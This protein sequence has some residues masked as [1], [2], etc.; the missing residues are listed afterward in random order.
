MLSAMYKKQ[1]IY[2]IPEFQTNYEILKLL[3]Y[4]NTKIIKI[5][6]LH[7]IYNTTII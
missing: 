4:Y 7:I 6:T 1:V 5:I 3:N 2:R